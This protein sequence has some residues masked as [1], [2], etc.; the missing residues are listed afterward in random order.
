[1]IENWLFSASKAGHVVEP[2][3]GHAKNEWKNL[4][5]RRLQEAECRHNNRHIPAPFYG[6]GARE[7]Q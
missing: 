1:M 6:Q 5:V 2:H 7:V 3:R 4:G